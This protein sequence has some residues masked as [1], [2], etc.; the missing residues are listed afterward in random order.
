MS[1]KK[2]FLYIKSVQY[3]AEKWW[4]WRKYQFGDFFSWSNTKFSK[5]II[6]SRIILYYIII[7]YK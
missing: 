4:E 1:I 7:N 6:I 2:E 5:L 3:Q